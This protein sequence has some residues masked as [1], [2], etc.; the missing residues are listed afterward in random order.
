MFLALTSV[1]CTLNP[2]HPF[3]G[4][5]TCWSDTGCFICGREFYQA[6]QGDL[7]ARAVTHES[8]TMWRPE[9]CMCSAKLC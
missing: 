6:R 3:T 1:Q 5:A 8:L 2:E 7:K 9:L 4:K